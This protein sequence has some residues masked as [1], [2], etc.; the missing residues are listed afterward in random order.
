MNCV[1]SDS[2]DLTT[3]FRGSDL[4]FLYCYL[5][6]S[7]TRTMRF[8]NTLSPRRV[9]LFLGILALYL[10]LQS[11]ISEYLLENVL[12]SNVD[13]V[14]IPFIDLLSVNAEETIPTWY[15]TLLLFISSLLIAFIAV[16]KQRNKEPYTGYW[17][18]LALIFLYLSMDEGAVI[19][20]ILSDPLQ[21]ALNTTGYLTFAWLIVFVP[22]V[23][24]FALS[25]LRFLFRLPPH[26]RNLF[27]LAGIL[28]VGG[29]IFV[30]AISANRYYLDDGVSFPYLALATIEE[31]CEM[32]GVALFIY[33]LLSYMAALE[34]TAVFHFTP[35]LPPTHP[36]EKRTSWKRPLG[37]AILI[38]ITLNLLMISWAFR[39]QSTTTN[40]A[41]PFYQ[42]MSDR[43]AGQGVIILQVNE[44]LDIN[45]AAA[46]P[47][48]SSLLTLFDDVLAVAMP[49][50]QTSIV[51][52]S[53]DLPFDKTALT[54][55]LPSDSEDQYTILDITAVRAI[56]GNH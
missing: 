24:L 26:T 44:V 54:E 33:A 20:E 7:I 47:I 35:T 6:F 18:G 28:F 11:L 43:Y 5:P 46:Q 37:V 17:V 51:F 32:L 38:I 55:L 21:E 25:Y 9:A 16:V 13:S 4:E 23:I 49:I 53:H 22:L 10:A 39:Q 42:E 31:L 40:V 12:G 29:A 1:W 30:E 3:H 15:S 41:T 45:N 19:H 27:I 52:A 14:V 8:E 36:L 2:H 56:A 34:Y 50:E 48:A